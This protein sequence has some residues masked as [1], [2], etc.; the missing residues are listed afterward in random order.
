MTI[1]MSI[2]YTWNA[3]EIIGFSI[4]EMHMNYYLYKYIS[5]Y[6]LQI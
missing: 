3:H 1:Y 2:Q 5:D 4:H 6:I